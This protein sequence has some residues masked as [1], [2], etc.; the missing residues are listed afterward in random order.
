MSL[1]KIVWSV[2][3]GVY[4]VF[5]GWYT[6][7][8]GPL[9]PEEI[10]DYLGILKGRGASSEEI[11]H[12]RDF[13]AT[14]TGD[15]FVMVNAIEM[16]DPP[17]QVEG[18]EPGETAAQVLEKYMAYMYPALFSRACHPVMMGRV[19]AVALDVWGIEDAERW[20][21]AG[22]MR[23]RSR[24]D[25]MDIATN[26]DFQGPHEFKIAAIRKTLAF[27]IDPWFQLG[28]P[29]LVFGLG[30]GVIGLLVHGFEGHR[31]AQ[32]RK[33]EGG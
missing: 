11:V 23:Y 27:P 3:L 7:F 13:L 16:R 29:R 22:M 28:D 32:R 4:A 12:V 26:P 15:D 33:T 1:P 31:R 25:M 6:S 5:F 2:L 9:S 8:G 10:D 18:V 30:F 14:D 24:R 20:T 21:M 17:M 19:A